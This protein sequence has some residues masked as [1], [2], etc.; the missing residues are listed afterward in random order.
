MLGDVEREVLRLARERLAIVRAQLDELAPL[1]R[2][3]KL[4]RAYI[5]VL[6]G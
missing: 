5:E 3:A 1:E 2:E 4:L 6:S